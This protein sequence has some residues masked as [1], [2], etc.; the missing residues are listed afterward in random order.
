[1][2]EAEDFMKEAQNNAKTFFE[3]QSK[4][5]NKKDL[6]LSLLTETIATG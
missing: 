3:K 1:M 6:V 2:K 4:K 5:D